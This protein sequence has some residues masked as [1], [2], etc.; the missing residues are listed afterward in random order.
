MKKPTLTLVL[1]STIC[2]LLF[3]ASSC[4][5]RSSLAPDKA[6]LGQ[7]LGTERRYIGA[8]KQVWW[9]ITSGRRSTEEYEITRV[10]ETD[11]AVRIRLLDKPLAPEWELRLAADNKSFDEVP[12]A[13]GKP[14]TGVNIVKWT[15]VD[16][17]QE[18]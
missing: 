12:I 16:D 11:R 1:C 7:W 10:S 14:M 5:G 8:K 6:I 3:F 18:P 13:D 2:T 17:K 9:D 15:Y 4:K